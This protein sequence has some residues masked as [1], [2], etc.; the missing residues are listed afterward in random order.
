MNRYSIKD[1]L[2]LTHHKDSVNYKDHIAIATV[3]LP[4]NDKVSGLFAIDAFTIGYTTH[5]SCVLE[6]NNETHRIKP[7]IIFILA[8]TH[9]C[10]FLEATDD[11]EVKIMMLDSNGHNLS[12]HLNYLVKSERWTQTYFHPTLELNPDQ[13]KRMKTCLD[14]IVEEIKRPECPNRTAILMLA[15]TWHHVELDNIMQENQKVISDNN[16]PLTRQQALARQLYRL[17]VNNYR[18]EHQ[19]K[20]YSEQMCLTPQYLNQ[21]T[22]TIFRKTLREIISDLLFSTARSMILASEMSIQEISDE[23]NFA[24]QASFSKFIKKESGVSPNTLRKTNPHLT[25]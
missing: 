20:F 7:G 9:T 4:D 25:Q 16:K 11:C 21:I 6:I 12:V 23:L 18:K 19:V 17:I 24:D 15:T 2:Q 13:A 10:R 14:R 3:A 22:K 1:I 5:G 8:P